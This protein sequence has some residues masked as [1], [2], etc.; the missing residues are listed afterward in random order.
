MSY[1]KKFYNFEL[2]DI[3]STLKAV[4][5]FAGFKSTNNFLENGLYKETQNG[6]VIVTARIENEQISQAAVNIVINSVI[7]YFSKRTSKRP[8]EALQEAILFA[9]KQLYIEATQNSN[10]IGKKLS[11]MVV[12]IR[13]KRIFYAYVGTNN[14]FIKERNKIIR[15]TPGKSRLE[16]DDYSETSY[17]NS[18]EYKNSLKIFVCKEPVIPET[19]D[20]VFICS[21]DFVRES[22]DF[23][24]QNLASPEK[25]ETI[26]TKLVKYAFAEENKK[27]ELTFLLLRFDIQGG[28]YTLAG[29]FE[30]LYANLISKIIAFITSVPALIILAVIIIILL[31]LMN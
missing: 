11:C 4:P 22:D 12:L 16:G 1:T 29:S 26:S 25:I 30:Y 7:S 9:N 31:I 8:L 17:I 20:L 18:S 5:S 13:E 28:K 24:K 21:D 19:D 10:L 23:I 14:L 27:S 15:L 6:F 3:P 2:I